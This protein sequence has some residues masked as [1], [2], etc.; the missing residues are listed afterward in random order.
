MK[1]LQPRP[2]R[3][4]KAFREQ[5]PAIAPGVAVKG[6][7]ANLRRRWFERLDQDLSRVTDDV[8]D[9]PVRHPGIARQARIDQDEHCELGV[10][11]L[12][13]NVDARVRMPSRHQGRLP[14]D[15]RVD[16]DLGSVELPV[17]PAA[18]LKRKVASILPRLRYVPRHF[19]ISASR[20]RNSSGKR[21]PN[22]R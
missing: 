1:A 19:L 11:N 12:P 16:V 9:S 2:G 17:A 18:S 13:S 8:E 4:V 22:S 3:I 20:G 15:E 6:T 21:N 7:K 10:V 5:E 14:V